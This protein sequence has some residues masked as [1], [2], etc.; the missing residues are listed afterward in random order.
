VIVGAYADL[1]VSWREKQGMQFDVPNASATLQQWRPAYAFFSTSLT[2]QPGA[3][4]AKDA[5]GKDNLL[6]ID[7]CFQGKT[8]L[9]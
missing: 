5:D 7:K 1:V 2:H 3:I 4:S 9:E 6:E 8:E